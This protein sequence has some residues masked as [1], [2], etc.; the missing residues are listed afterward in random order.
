MPENH[1]VEK[2][3]LWQL[4]EE[5]I[6]GL[7]DQDF[8]EDKMSETTSK[9]AEELDKTGY[10]VSLSGGNWLQLKTAV[11]ARIQVGK[12]FL[13]DFN[14]AVSALTLDDVKDC[15]GAAMKIISDLGKVWPSF[16][17][18]ENRPDVLKIVEQT[19]LD[20]LVA[21]AKA[22]SG[23]EG[24]RSLIAEEL[25]SQ[26][27]IDSLGVSED[28]YTKVK[29]KVDAEI[30]EKKRVENMLAGLADKAENDKVKE[31]LNKN[32]AD[33][34]IVEIA[35]IGQSVID[36]VKKSMEEELAE[37]KRLEEEAAAKKAEEAAGPSLDSIDNDDMLEYIE[38]LR[39]ILDFSDKES[40]IRSMAE[41]SSIPVCL[42]D[43]AVSD[44]DKL[45]E[46]EEKA[47]G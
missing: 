23:D 2:E 7:S 8:S 26:V 5:K 43:I 11:K 36:T 16:Q 14:E 39:E 21:K 44:P 22:L 6:N 18:S 20:L 40:E 38:G 19:K 47:E 45:D 29:A 9:I 10:N 4:I 31:L 3:P 12:P 41:Q 34:L 24:I 30:A 46:L 35:G 17:V 37:K 42:V 27:I 28:E 33:K 15:Y 25:D 1:I 32:V 13:Q